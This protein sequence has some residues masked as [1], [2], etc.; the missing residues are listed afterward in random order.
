MWDFMKEN[1]NGGDNAD[2]FACQEGCPNG[3]AVSQIVS[4][5][6]CQVQIPGYFDVSCKAEVELL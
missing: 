6:C 2:T 4:E 5:I 1:C 3:K